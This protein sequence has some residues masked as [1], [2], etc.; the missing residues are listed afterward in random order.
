MI[1]RIEIWVLKLSCAMWAYFVPIKGVF[2]AIIALWFIDLC[3]G[4]W[5]S[6]L[7][8]RSL[9]SYKLRKSLSKLLSYIIA[10]IAANILDVSLLDSSL[11]LHQIVAVYIGIT[12][13]TSIYEN[14][15]VITGQD[16][17][18]SILIKIKESIN[19]KMKS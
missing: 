8:K 9:T 19:K 13:L 12:E 5:K 2:I 14:L 6:I 10:I 3:S 18:R 15:A 1:E 4:I 16:L 7:K 17:L 11:N